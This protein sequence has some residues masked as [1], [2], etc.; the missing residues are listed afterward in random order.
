MEINDTGLSP[1]G[2][3]TIKNMYPMDFE[4]FMIAN[5]TGEEALDFIRKSYKECKSLSESLHNSLMNSFNAY[6]YT[7][8]LPDCVKTY[9]EEKTL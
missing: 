7:G 9:V 8:G 5:G 6:L 1:M 4:E 3:I 2:S